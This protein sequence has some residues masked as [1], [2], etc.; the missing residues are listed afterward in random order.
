MVAP[1]NGSMAGVVLAGGASR[2]LGRDKALVETGGGSL[3]AHAAAKLRAV[4]SEVLAAD[5][6]R[7]VVPGLAS[8]PDGDGQGP[9]AGILGAARARPGRALLVLACD[10]PE[11]PVA[12]L[13]ALAERVDP[14]GRPERAAAADWVVPRWGGRL[15][16]LCALYGPGALAAL[17]R[18][19]AAGRF[20]LHELATE[21]GLAARFLE[22]PELTRFG[23]PEELFVN[24]NSPSD[25]ARWLE[26]RDGAR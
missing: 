3:A 2:R 18:R 21:R 8:V 4:C 13:A 9:A 16:P 22:G 26:R 14:G 6:G 1:G 15:E 25:L 17:G 19:V 7:Q 10:L 11:V 23:D 12:L 5:A 20:A 24:L